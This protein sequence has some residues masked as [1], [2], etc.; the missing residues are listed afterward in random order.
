[1][2]RSSKMTTRILKQRDFK[3]R[4]TPVLAKNLLGKFLARKRGVKTDYFLI[5][6]TEAYHGPKDMASHASNG[7]TERNEPMFGHSGR[8]YLYMI[9]GMH[10]ML[11]IV[12]GPKDYP[13]AI[14]IRGVRGIRGP[15][16][17]TQKLR[18]TKTLNKKEAARKSGLYIVDRGVRIPAKNIKKSP[19]IGVEYA[20]PLWG[21]KHY[22]FYIK[23]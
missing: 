13:A 9:Y 23:V 6:E 20:G 12:T 14:L 8:W 22:R 10:Q 4:N 2:C 18:I 21:K 7:K 5:T 19:R 1:M 16:R 17:L 15:G 11:N 3:S